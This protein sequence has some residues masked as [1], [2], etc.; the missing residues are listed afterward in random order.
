LFRF[1]HASNELLSECLNADIECLRRVGDK[2]VALSGTGLFGR[3][4]GRCDLVLPPCCNRRVCVCIAGG[5]GSSATQ[6]VVT[7]LLRYGVLPRCARASSVLW[8]C[9]SGDEEGDNDNVFAGNGGGPP[10]SVGGID[11]KS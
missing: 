11:E 10:A 4:R 2:C 9:A 8:C 1:D 7:T 6:G 5:F 3:C